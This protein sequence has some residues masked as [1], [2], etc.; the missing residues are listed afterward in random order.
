MTIALH[1]WG[2]DRTG[3][4]VILLHGWT[5]SGDIWAPL[6]QALPAP[7]LAPDLPGHGA[8]T[9]YPATVEGGVAQLGDLIAANGLRDATLVGWSLGA[10]IGWHY[11][12]RGGP[13][14]ARMVS[15]DMSPCPLPAPGWNF[16]M[17]NQSAGKAARAAARFEQDWPRAARA[18][19]QTMFARPQGCTAMSAGRAEARIRARDPATM[20]RF[21]T[22]LTR[23]DLRDA[24][25]RLP[26]PLLALHGAKSRVYAPATGDWLACTAPDG[27]NR[28][29]ADCGHAPVL[30]TPG[31]TAGIIAEFIRA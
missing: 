25:T 18:I 4:P 10:L 31:A 1:R 17:R 20:A 3:A 21:W 14:I 19:A 12:D 28:T 15:V 8:S 6:A 23:T 2:T 27:R 16:P 11:L 24:I 29:L 30:E 26:V 9:A 5:M 22:S 7:C 13:G